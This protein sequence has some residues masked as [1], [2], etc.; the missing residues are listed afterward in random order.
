MSAL[1][2]KWSCEKHAIVSL[3]V[4]VGVTLPTDLD[5]GSNFAVEGGLVVQSGSSIVVQIA[6]RPPSTASFAP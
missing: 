3:N 1:L 6:V 5:S 2:K 4:K